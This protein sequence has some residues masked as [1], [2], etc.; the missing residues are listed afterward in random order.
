MSCN[1]NILFF[2]LGIFCISR[3]AA[4]NEGYKI[5]VKLA[6]QGDTVLYLAHYF[7]NKTLLDDT[8]RINS[9]GVFVFENPE[10]AD[11]GMYIVL[12]AKKVKYFDFFLTGKQEMSFKCD[13]TDVVASMVVSGSHENEVFFDYMKYM[14]DKRKDANHLREQLKAIDDKDSEKA[15]ALSEKI[16]KIDEE[17]RAQLKKIQD[18]NASLLCMKFLKAMEDPDYL[19]Y[20]TDASGKVDSSK[21]FQAF[22]QHYWDHFDFSDARLLYTP[23]FSQ[24]VDLYFSEKMVTPTVDSMKVAINYLLEKS[25]PSPEMQKYMAWYL[26]D[27]AQKMEIMGMDALVV[28]IVKDILEAGKVE[29]YY[30]SVKETAIKRANAMEP[31]LIGKKAPQLI[32]QDTSGNPRDLYQVNAKYTLIFL[33]E[34]NCSHCKKEMPNLLAFY[35]DFHE[36]YDLEVFGISTDTIPA[37]WKEYVRKNNMQWINVNGRLAYKGNYSRLYDIHS[38]P[39]MFLLDDKKTIIAKHIL[40]DS[41]KMI[42]QDL[43]EKKTSKAG[44][45]E[46]E[47]KSQSQ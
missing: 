33:W 42:L 8:A 6:N 11:E 23:V 17:V 1:K 22:K 40:T 21:M 27:L 32:L 19:K 46:S 14:A 10:K 44:P 13:T 20:C 18:Q 26:L 28:Y 45:G 41:L 47:T 38:T 5:T 16:K 31:S 2:L 9:K 37:K 7:S 43:E 29:W 3:L 15:K 39:Q 24:K 30:P 36:K 34:S 4:S 35:K 25:K 12:N